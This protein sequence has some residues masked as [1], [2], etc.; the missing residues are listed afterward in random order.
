MT[1]KETKINELIVKHT[2]H[3]EV[4]EQERIL[5]HFEVEMNAVLCS[6]PD[7]ISV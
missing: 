4:A 7:L 2:G 1:D 3:L 6:P 5:N